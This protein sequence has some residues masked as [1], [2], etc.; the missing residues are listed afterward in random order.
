M[1]KKQ[2]IMTIVLLLIIGIAFTLLSR[3]VIGA[4]KKVDKP[5]NYAEVTATKLNVK[6]DK[7]PVTQDFRE[8]Q[9]K[10]KKAGKKYFNYNGESYKTNRSYAELTEYKVT[11][12][13]NYNNKD[14]TTFKTYNNKDNIKD[15]IEVYINKN[16]TTDILTS[17]PTSTKI[18][19][20]IMGYALRFFG[21]AGLVVAIA[22]AINTFKNRNKVSLDKQD[23][24]VDLTKD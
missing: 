10:A 11:Y 2:N 22:I 20:K 12:E 9:K 13:F 5:E 6:E 18:E 4:S 24:K 15:T 3:T 1:K 21:V 19:L 8:D 23:D 17:S 14:F 7:K 16:D